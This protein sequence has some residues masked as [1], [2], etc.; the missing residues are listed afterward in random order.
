MSDEGATERGREDLA[1]RLDAVERTLTGDDATVADLRDAAGRERR[2]EALERTVADLEGRVDELEATLQSVR[3]FL[4]GVE[5]VNERVERR[6]DAALA[7][8]ERL[9]RTA[10]GSESDPKSRSALVT[11]RLDDSGGDGPDAARDATDA[12][13]DATDPNTTAGA[14]ADGRAGDPE[15]RRGDSD[16]TDDGDGADERGLAARVREAL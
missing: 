14:S 8:V 13:R 7:A 5:A 10:H 12:A 16:G 6:A 15:P 9:E 1:A 3:G 4:G 11:S 2:V